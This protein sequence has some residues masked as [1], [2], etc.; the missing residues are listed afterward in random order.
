MKVPKEFTRKLEALVMCREAYN[1]MMWER[2]QKKGF[3]SR[4]RRLK[5]GYPEREEE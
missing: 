3:K 4:K 5:E 1:R 2:E